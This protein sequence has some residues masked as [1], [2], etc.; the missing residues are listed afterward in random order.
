MA[1]EEAVMN[2]LSRNGGQNYLEKTPQQRG[3]H[4]R[5]SLGDTQ[6]AGWRM[7]GRKVRIRMFLVTNHCCVPLLKAASD[8]GGLS[9]NHL[10]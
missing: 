10:L 5:R 3:T 2:T 6:T 1:R 7:H 4:S 9:H 8:E